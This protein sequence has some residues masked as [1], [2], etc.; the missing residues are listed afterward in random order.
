MRDPCFITRGIFS[1]SANKTGLC[2]NCFSDFF[3]PLLR[4]FE[5]VFNRCDEDGA[6][7]EDDDND[8]DDDDDD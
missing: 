8:E 1:I 6:D 7:D 4:L 2:A 5:I 3:P